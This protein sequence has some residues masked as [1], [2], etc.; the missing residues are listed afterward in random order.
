MSQ[1]VVSAPS[2]C[3]SYQPMYSLVPMTSSALPRGSSTILI[4]P[5]LDLFGADEEGCGDEASGVELMSEI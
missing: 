5:P 3:C 1:V 2:A 4:V